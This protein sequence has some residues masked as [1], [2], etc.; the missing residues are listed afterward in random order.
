MNWRRLVSSSRMQV[1]GAILAT[2]GV[3]AAMYSS[4]AEQGALPEA[5]VAK[6]PPPGMV[7]FAPDAVQL[8]SIAVRSVHLEAMP[9]SGPQTGRVA[10]DENNTTRITSPIAG[11]VLALHAEV[12]DPVKAGQTLADLDSPDLATA[13]ADW[14][15]AR[16]DELRKQRAFER[17]RTLFQGE[18]LARKDLE[19]AQADADQAHFE[20]RRAVLRMRN[21]NAGGS[22]DGVFQLKARLTGI[23]A[24]RQ[25]NPGQEVRPD[26]TAPLFV[27]TVLDTLW[28]LVDVPEQIAVFLHPGQGVVVETDAWPGTQFPARVDRVGVLLDP[29]TRRIQVRCIVQNPQRKLKPEMF[30]KV[31][32]L[33]DGAAAQ[34]IALPNASLFTEGKYS[35]VFVQTRPGTFEKRRVNVRR[36][37]AERS[38]IDA[39]L[40]DGEQV[41]TDGVLLLS[42]EVG[43]D[44]R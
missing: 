29:G 3:V 41:V 22:Q 16:A 6:A 40:A 25:I 9:V 15:K 26:M 39:G 18:V 11:R 37:E 36:W 38:F 21:L 10:Y 35:Y 7:T 2:S 31:S 5:M 17:A 23:V 4:R 19:G 43:G 13:E 1:A 32:F 20:T 28:V 12:G 24:E 44:A 8:S 34:A 30:A 42:T 14:Q 33:P 27:L